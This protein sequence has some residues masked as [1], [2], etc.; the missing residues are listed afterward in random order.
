MT[1]NEPTIPITQIAGMRYYQQQD[2]IHVYSFTDS[3]RETVDAL[4]AQGRKNDLDAH[5]K[6]EHMR[7]LVNAR[8]IWMTPYGIATLLKSAQHTPLG[9]K[10]STAVVLNDTFMTGVLIGLLQKLPRSVQANVRLFTSEADA[11]AWLDAREEQ[12]NVHA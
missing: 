6:N 10:E 9:L 12:L 3:R 11:L 5:S 7:A 8:G 1:T 4:I 2:G